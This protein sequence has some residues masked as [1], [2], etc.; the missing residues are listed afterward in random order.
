VWEFSNAHTESRH[1]ILQSFKR[2]DYAL[3]CPRGGVLMLL[4]F[5]LDFVEFLFMPF[6]SERCQ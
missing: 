3:A 4:E 2:R 6:V 5:R 1:R